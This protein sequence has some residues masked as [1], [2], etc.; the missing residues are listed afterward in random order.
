MGV[1]GS[2]TYPNAQSGPASAGL[3]R[4]GRFATPGHIARRNEQWLQ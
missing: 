3:M 2:P 1:G 4:E